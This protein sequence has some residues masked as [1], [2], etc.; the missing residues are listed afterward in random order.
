[1]L[2]GYMT[3]VVRQVAQGRWEQS[4]ETI[5]HEFGIGETFLF[6]LWRGFCTVIVS[7]GPCLL[8]F[9]MLWTGI[10]GNYDHNKVNEQKQADLLQAEGYKR[11]A[12]DMA[13]QNPATVL[14]FNRKAN[15]LEAKWL[16]ADGA[17]NDHS[18]FADLFARLWVAAPGLMRGLLILSLIWAVFYYP[19]ALAVVGY[20]ESG[21]AGLNP[22]IGLDTMKRLAG[23]YSKA[24]LM[25]LAV[26]G[27]G[28][29][30][31]KLA[32]ASLAGFTL[33][34][35]G[36]APAR[37]L[38]AVITFYACLVI[39]CLLGLLLYKNADALGLATD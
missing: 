14:E 21:T 9:F 3:S 23:D 20:T 33:P 17:K 15:E 22:A 28:G 16:K 8:L 18:L 26:G 4:S 7:W 37:F 25:Y 12:R 36:N 27:L 38:D 29:F 13:S 10:A 39:S 2:F 30:L 32:F 5:N 6:P 24:F 19:M 34:V 35:M 31:S 11:M 1:L